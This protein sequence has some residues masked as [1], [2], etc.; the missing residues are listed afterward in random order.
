MKIPFRLA[1]VAV[2]VGLLLVTGGSLIIYSAIR[3]RQDVEILKQA[4]LEKTVEVGV[5]AVLQL[6][7]Q[8]ETI[9]L[10]Q[11]SL[12]EGKALPTEASIALGQVFASVLRQVPDLTWLSYGEEATGRFAGANRVGPKK[13]V[14]NVS[15]PA[16]NHGVPQE[17]RADRGANL[18]PFV[19]T[20]PLTEPYDPR[21]RLWYQRAISARDGI[22]WMPPYM[23]AEGVK[24]VTAAVAVRVEPG[25][26]IRG[27][28]T[29]DFSLSGIDHFL[30][31]V[32]VGQRGII[33]LFTRDGEFLGGGSG[34]GLEAVRR[35]RSDRTLPLSGSDGTTVRTSEVVGGLKYDILARS[36]S[37]SHGLD[38]IIV[39]SVPEEDFMGTVY[40][41]R[42]IAV[43]I[44]LGGLALAMCTGFLLSTRIANS[45]VGVTE[46]LGRIAK[47]TIGGAAA[48]L[49][50]LKEISLLQEAVVR[51]KASLRSFTHFAPEEIVREV[52]VSGR[53]TMLSGEKRE[54]T[55]LFCDLRGFTGFAEKTRPEAL[56]AILNDHFDTLSAIVVKHRG[57]VIDFLG[58]SVFAAFGA[59]QAC[60]DHAARAVGCAIE[61]QLARW[62]RDGENF[63]RGWPPLE[64]GIGINTGSAVVGNMGSNLRIKYGV[65]GHPVNLA[66]RIET[67]TAAG[68]ILVSDST[69]EAIGDLLVAQGPLEAEGKGV[70]SIIRMWDVRG[71]KGP[72]PLEL[73]SPL[74]DLAVI[75]PP[76]DAYVRLI[77]GKEID[78]EAYPAE[79]L[80][81]GS[82]GAQVRTSALMPA[83]GGVQVLFQWEDGTSATLNGRIL[84]G[85]EQEIRQ[86]VV[87]VRFEGLDWNTRARL[88]AL[89]G[90]RVAR[91]V[92]GD[93]LH[94]P[95]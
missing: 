57:Y 64:I 91:Y 49:S 79:L 12:A 10:A 76:L 24:G 2:V 86:C 26:A 44:T 73:P 14:V 77:H 20:P 89:V 48:P 35:A 61:M 33:L 90:S 31:S 30:K 21:T 92:Q 55:L 72:T 1:I 59:L 51:V 52:V 87:L 7:R 47:L 70:G 37:P 9:L 85:S 58:D 25:G 3:S 66:A 15:D 63:S 93:A 17:F 39:I 68:Q 34:S 46:E 11:R 18:E 23:F 28:L 84:G 50:V 4:Y 41:N 95:I 53:E 60:P 80:R 78:A 36:V 40:A 22:I 32:K 74:S 42:R 67:F 45:L 43:A 16:R 75:D 27:V 71:L 65:V 82:A 6:P 5:E 19:R 54:V 13:I 56:V 62:T 88:K 29:A 83:F 69:R 8:V 38:W 94:K 81:L